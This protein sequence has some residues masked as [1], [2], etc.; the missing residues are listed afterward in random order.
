M[1]KET[2]IRWPTSKFIKV[3]CLKCRNEQVIFDK[4]ATEIKC[5]NC[6]EVIARPTG[7]KV[8]LINAEIVKTF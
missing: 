6:G 5:L 1:M 3:R 4:A 7:G 2:I 8:E